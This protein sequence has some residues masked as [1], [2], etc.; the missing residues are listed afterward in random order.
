MRKRLETNKAV[1][2]KQWL[3]TELTSVK[4]LST[5]QSK[6]IPQNIKKI[7]CHSHFFLPH[8]LSNQTER[9]CTEKKKVKNNI[10]PQIQCWNKPETLNL[11]N[12][13]FH[14]LKINQRR[15]R[16]KHQK[17]PWRSRNRRQRHPSTSDQKKPRP[18]AQ[19]SETKA[20]TFA[21][22]LRE[23]NPTWA[24]PSLFPRSLPFSHPRLH[25]R[26]RS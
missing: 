21:A 15:D 5:F 14:K 3:M 23:D 8:F 13:N 18:A 9:K 1:I 17:W 2:F 7:K 6:K 25:L 4:K 19:P 22:E 10:P 12:L 26:R 20:A 16:I 24:P 11:K